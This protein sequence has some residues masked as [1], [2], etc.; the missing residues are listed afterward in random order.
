MTSSA[1]T[2][3]TSDSIIR[4]AGGFAIVSAIVSGF[5]IVFLIANSRASRPA[6]ASQGSSLD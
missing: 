5:G 3:A 6:A 4:A 2:S 1:D